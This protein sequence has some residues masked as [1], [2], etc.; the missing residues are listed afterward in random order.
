[1]ERERELGGIGGWAESRRAI[2]SI[3]L[4]QSKIITFE[5]SS[6]GRRGD[7]WKEEYPVC[8]GSAGWQEGG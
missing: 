7:R 2:Q 4:R 3:S 6:R 8:L 5:K 1:M